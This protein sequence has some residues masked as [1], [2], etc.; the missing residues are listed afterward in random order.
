MKTIDKTL[1]DATVLEIKS[2]KTRL[3][4]IWNEICEK[5]NA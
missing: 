1:Y 3:D 4:E 2:L 5:L